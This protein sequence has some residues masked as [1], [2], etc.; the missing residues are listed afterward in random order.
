MDYR[1]FH[2]EQN[3]THTIN[4]F[5]QRLVKNMKNDI[6]MINDINRYSNYYARL[7]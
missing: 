2:Q 4:N 7:Q 1:I 5:N 3:R 6:T